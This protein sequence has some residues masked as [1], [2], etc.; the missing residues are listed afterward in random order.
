MENN[1][2]LTKE[3]IKILKKYAE[4]IEK[5]YKSK[6]ATNFLDSDFDILYPIYRKYISP[7]NLNKSCGRCRLRLLSSLYTLIKKDN[8]E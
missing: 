5:A 2:T 4:L 7:K 6:T 8:E 3:E 1:T